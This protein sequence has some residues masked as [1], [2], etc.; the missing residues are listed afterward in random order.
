VF[1][2]IANFTET[3]FSNMFGNVKE[4][5]QAVASWLKGDG[6]DWEWTSLTKG[7]EITLKELPNIVGREL[8]A[9]EAALQASV[10]KQG[11]E[12][13]MTFAERYKFALESLGF[14][15]DEV[16]PKSPMVPAAAIAAGGAAAVVAVDDAAGGK[17]K[18]EKRSQARFE[19]FSS[20]FN[21]IQGSAATAGQLPEVRAA[22]K[23]AMAAE[24]GAKAG[25]TAISVLKRIDANTRH[26]R[27]QGLL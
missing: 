16:D 8:T 14:D 3:V 12:L 18:E 24:R 19:D 22:E 10:A 25:E 20:L 15:R 2:A 23:G 6:F 9:T 11:L 27:P 13:G 1:S 4:F 5:F 21:R 17:A 7:L 26:D